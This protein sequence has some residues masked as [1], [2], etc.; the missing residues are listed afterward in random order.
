MT[1]KVS[2]EHKY[3]YHYTNYQGLLGILESQ[4]IW[5][6]HFQF[7]N[8]ESEF[9][10]FKKELNEHL[11]PTVDKA[12]DDFIKQDA[13]AKK[14]LK[15]SGKSFKEVVKSETSVLAKAIYS[16]H[17]DQFYISSFSGE[18]K[19]NDIEQNENGLLS[20]WRAY[21]PDG[22]FILVFNTLFFFT[23]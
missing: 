18:S 5:A 22:G 11:E 16:G 2:D 6:T 14:F 9:Q 8:D 23:T 19:T 21:G 7:L 17:D 12:Y 10:L 1:N 20:Q 4:C 3:L 15:D 13:G